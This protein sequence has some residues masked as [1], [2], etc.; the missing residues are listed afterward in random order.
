PGADAGPGRP[1]RGGAE[2][3]RQ[4][5]RVPP[6]RQGGARLFL[7]RPARLSAGAGGRRLEEDLDIPGGEPGLGKAKGGSAPLPTP[8]PRTGCAGKARARAQHRAVGDRST[9][10]LA[11]TPTGS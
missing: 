8:P 1:A 5:L 9:A 2:E 3:A 10:S 11:D 7:L 4:E 6:L